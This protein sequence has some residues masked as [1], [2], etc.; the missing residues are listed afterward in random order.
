[1]S[2]CCSSREV[3]VV[4]DGSDSTC[5]LH[6]TKQLSDGTAGDIAVWF[7]LMPEGTQDI[8]MYGE[9]V[10]GEADPQA[11][12]FGPYDWTANWGAE[13][14]FYRQSGYDDVPDETVYITAYE[15]GGV[16]IHCTTIG[17][18]EDGL[19]NEFEGIFLDEQLTIS[20]Q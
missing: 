8:Y 10:M 1:M 13:G 16:R 19:I 7:E 2:C 15:G 17:P 12:R 3:A 4:D 5:L 14:V 11:E 9:Y 20:L 18:L 6:L